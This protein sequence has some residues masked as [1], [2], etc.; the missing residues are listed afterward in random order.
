MPC[1]PNLEKLLL[2]DCPSL[3]MISD[4]IGDHKK[5]RLIDK[6]EEELEQ[7]KSLVNL[8]ANRT[9]ITK[10]PYSIIRSK[11]IRY[12]S[13]CGY[14]G[15]SHY[16]FPSLIWNWMSPTKILSLSTLIPTS[17]CPEFVPLYVIIKH[18][19]LLCSKHKQ[20][21]KR[22]LDILDAAYC[23]QIEAKQTASQVANIESCSATIHDFPNQFYISGSAKSLLIGAGIKSQFTNILRERIIQKLT[24]SGPDECMLSSDNYYSVTFNCEGSFVIFEVPH[25]NGGKLKSMMLC[26]VF[27]SS[28]ETKISKCLQEVLIKVY[29]R[30]SVQVYKYNTQTFSEELL[31]WQSLT[32]KLEPGTKVEVHAFPDVGFTVK[33]SEIYLVYNA[34]STDF[35][36]ENC[37]V[38]DMII[39]E[40]PIVSGDD[41]MATK[42]MYDT[43]S[44]GDDDYENHIH[45][46]KARFSLPH[47]SR[48]WQALHALPRREKIPHFICCCALADAVTF[49]AADMVRRFARSLLVD[50]GDLVNSWFCCGVISDWLSATSS[51]FL[52]VVIRSPPKLLLMQEDDPVAGIQE[53]IGR[54]WE[55]LCQ[56]LCFRDYI[57]DQVVA[58]VRETCA[59]ALGAAFKY[60]HLAL[61]NETLNILL[62]MQC[63]QEWE[64]RHGS[65][66]G[67]AT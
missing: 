57:S 15:F 28:L 18:H 50:W 46:I 3:N 54:N 2:K 41:N 48:R 39:D 44:G 31:N 58:P 6:L 12:I 1:L 36:L 11:S 17:A 65:L 35:N 32:S 56:W 43:A 33:K 10:V 8:I 63:R 47:G 4:T 27:S 23:N 45:P 49:G 7:M 42:M 38:D 16:V 55:L 14:E 13:I 62:K 53:L 21:V 19:S 26:I 40:N 51:P 29:T 20:G 59:D 52:E 34:A 37:Q 61:V 60:M 24:V 64:I 30:T 25:V 22:V 67:T 66:L 5:I 9:S